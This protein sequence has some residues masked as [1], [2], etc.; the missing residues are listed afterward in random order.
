MLLTALDESVFL[1]NLYL[2]C[3]VKH[4]RV[5]LSKIEHDSLSETAFYVIRNTPSTSFLLRPGTTED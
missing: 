5:F 1:S 3:N 2:L 4:V